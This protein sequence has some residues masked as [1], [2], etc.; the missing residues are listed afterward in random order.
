MPV[1]I[2]IC[3][4]QDLTIVEYCDPWSLKGYFETFPAN[5]STSEDRPRKC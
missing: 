2:N 4:P 1:S 3:Q 5:E